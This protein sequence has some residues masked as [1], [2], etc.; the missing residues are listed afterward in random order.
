MHKCHD[1]DH[2]A[3]ERRSRIRITLQQGRISPCFHMF[4]CDH[5][6]EHSI[7]Y[8]INISRCT[9]NSTY[10]RRQLEVIKVMMYLPD[11]PIYL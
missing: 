4:T 8:S 11:L 10:K 1:T 7:A 5:S 9:S 6:T 2:V 3:T